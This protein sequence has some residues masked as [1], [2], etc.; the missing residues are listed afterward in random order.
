L[1]SPPGQKSQKVRLGFDPGRG[2]AWAIAIPVLDREKPII[3]PLLAIFRNNRLIMNGSAISYQHVTSGSS[4]DRSDRYGIW[5]ALVITA[6]P[7]KP[8]HGLAV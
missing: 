6:M 8:F 5:C 7:W 3:P 2:I 1:S 4:Q